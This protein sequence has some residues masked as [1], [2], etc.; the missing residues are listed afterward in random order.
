MAKGLDV[1]GFGDVFKQAQSMQARMQS[2]TGELK[3]RIVEAS[4]GGGMVTAQ[5]NGAS[6]LVNIKIAKEVVDPDD[7]EM[8]EDLVVAAVSQ[9]LRKAKTL[10]ETE[11]GK[12]TGGLNLPGL[13]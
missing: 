2:L 13:F 6:E 3:E 8:L 9:A 5:A 10:H 7:V 11:M 4:A 1:S 12:I